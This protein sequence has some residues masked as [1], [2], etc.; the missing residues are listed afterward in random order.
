MRTTVAFLIAVL[1][2]GACSSSSGNQGSVDQANDVTDQ[3]GWETIDDVEDALGA[4][5]YQYL[6]DDGQVYAYE[7]EDIGVV[8]FRGGQPIRI[9]SIVTPVP[10]PPTGPTEYDCDSQDDIPLGECEALVALYLASG[11]PEWTYRD[12]GFTWLRESTQL[13]PCSW[14]GVYC[15]AT[16]GESSNVGGLDSAPINGLTLPEPAELQAAFPRLVD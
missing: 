5:D 1:V 11:G 4:A 2:L 6:V 9:Q 13:G 3:Y 14:I 12:S 16:P 15:V 7:A 8:T 10:L